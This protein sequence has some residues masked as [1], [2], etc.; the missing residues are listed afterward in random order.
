MRLCYII[1]L[2]LA[3]AL[4][5]VVKCEFEERFFTQKLV[6]IDFLD[7]REWENLYYIDEEYYQPGGPIFVFVGGADFYSTIYRL[8]TSHFFDIGREMHALLIA[9]E[10]RFFGQSRPTQ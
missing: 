7:Q 9:T 1:P 2:L 10:H 5:P 3:V 8:N 4:I 6:P